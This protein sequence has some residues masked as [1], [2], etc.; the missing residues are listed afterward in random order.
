MPQRHARKLASACVR[1][2]LRKAHFADGC[3]ARYSMASET[4]RILSASLSGISMLN[5]SSNAMTTST[6]S[7]LSRPSSDWKA[8]LGL[9]CEEA[10]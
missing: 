5:S 4:D 7:R 8:L 1:R 2:P 10:L 9:T 6:V 3:A